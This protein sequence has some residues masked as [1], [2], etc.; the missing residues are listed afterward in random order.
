VIDA[1]RG[2]VDRAVRRELRGVDEQLGAASSATGHIS[3]VTFE[4]PVTAS[5]SKRSLRSARSQASSSSSAELVKG[6]SRTSWRRQGSML[7]WCSTGLLRTRV[8]AGIV[9]AMTLMASVVLRT[10]TTWSSA[11]APTKVAT[12]GRASSN[13]AVD[14][15]DFAPLPRWTLLYQGTNASMAAHT[16][17]ITGVLAA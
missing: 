9:A 3:P 4:A 5:R 12:E 10:K 11:R 14:T 2:H 15:W 6:S 1:A 16:S 7:A 17:A 13:A 8:P